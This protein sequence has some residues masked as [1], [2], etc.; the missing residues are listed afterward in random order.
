LLRSGGGLPE[1]AASEFLKVIRSFF[2][3]K[4]AVLVLL[5]AGLALSG[6]GSSSHVG[7][8]INGNWRATLNSAGNETFA[9]VTD[10]TVNGDGSLGTSSLNFTVNNMA[11]CTFPAVAESGSFTLSGNLNG[12]VTG[13]FHYVVSSTGENMNVLTLDGTVSGG[14]I[15]GTWIATGTVGCSGNGTFTMTP[16][17]MG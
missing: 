4:I 6:C 11:P 8:N 5:A 9:F 15:T 2:M 1:R 14:Q 13:H 16:M 3:N 17:P 7:G 12:Q 10:I